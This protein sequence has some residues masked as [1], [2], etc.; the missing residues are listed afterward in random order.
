MS[1][2][3]GMTREV[4]DILRGAA[5][6]QNASNSEE[7][8]ADSEDTALE[9][10]LEDI[11][12][13]ADLKQAGAEVEWL[14]EGWI[15]KGAVNL[16]VAEGGIGKTRLLAD[17]NR[18]IVQGRDWPDGQSMRL[19]ADSRTL[20]VL[21]DDHHGEFVSLLESFRVP[22]DL[23]CIN[24]PKKN[25]YGGT[26]LDGNEMK[27]LRKRIEVAKPVFVAIDTVGGATSLDLCSQKEAGYFFKPL[28]RIARDYQVP[29]LCLHHLNASGDVLGRRATERARIVIKMTRPDP[30]QEDRRRLEVKKS[31]L[32]RPRP[33]GV[34]MGTGGNEYDSNPPSEAEPGTRQGGGDPRVEQCKKWLQEE[35]TAGA[36]LVGQLRKTGENDKGFSSKT[37]YAAKQALA[38]DEY[39]ALNP[40]YPNSTKLYKWWRLAAQSSAVPPDAEAF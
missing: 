8:D 1:D 34:T 22:L 38:L 32:K 25:P 12:T 16:I 23:A 18:R 14:W 17:L 27:R 37:I 4:E 3:N 30:A 7:P 31:N 15:Q 40:A 19:P 28:Q 35:L 36:K 21:A 26:Y 24:A 9:L 20:W 11:P 33:L 2:D 39:D 13:A 29:I 10:T 6:G 5:A